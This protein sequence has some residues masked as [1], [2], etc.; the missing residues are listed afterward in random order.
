MPALEHDRRT[1]LGL[2]TLAVCAACTEHI[3]ASGPVDA[4]RLSEVGV[5]YL[6]FVAQ[7]SL[8]I[9]RDEAGLYA[10][11]AFCS[12]DACDMSEDGELTAQGLVC[13][14]CNSLFDRFGAVKRSPATRPLQHFA[15]TVD[16]TGG[17][18]VDPSHVVAFDA[19]TPAVL[20]S[21]VDA[22]S[23]D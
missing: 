22:G 17:L 13:D 14:C 16:A 15:V 18:T 7:Q 20:G 23:V 4:G 1:F 19:R 5:G 11:S 8:L 21:A 2:C 12:F 9:G 3:Q 6:G 10:L